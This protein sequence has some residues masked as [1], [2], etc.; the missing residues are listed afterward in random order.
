MFEFFGTH[1]LRVIPT[2]RNEVQMNGI[3]NRAISLAVEM[4]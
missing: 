3:R 1:T 4:T 2:T